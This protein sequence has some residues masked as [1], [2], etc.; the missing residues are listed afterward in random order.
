[1]ASRLAKTL[2]ERPI[3]RIMSSPLARAID[4][5]GPLARNLGLDIKTDL[6]LL[7]F[8]FG[9]YEGQSKKA[10]GLKLRQ[11]HAATPVPGGEALIDVWDRAGQFLNDLLSRH[12]PVDD[13]IA[14]VGHYWINRMIFGRIA[15]LDFETACRT[16]TYRPAT[17]SS[18]VLALESAIMPDAGPPSVNRQSASGRCRC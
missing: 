3:A 6:N 11:S 13:E 18:V 1:M 2:S 5:A 4:T 7:E 17:G 9:S 10:L 14:V 12:H 16:R 8:D 15:G